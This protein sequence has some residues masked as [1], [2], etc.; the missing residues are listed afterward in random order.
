M[1]SH[2]DSVLTATGAM[3]STA[4]KPLP[5]SLSGWSDPSS[6]LSGEPIPAAMERDSGSLPSRFAHGTRVF[7]SA[8]NNPPT[9]APPIAN[10]LTMLC[11]QFNALEVV[12]AR[13]TGA[14]RLRGSMTATWSIPSLC[15]QWPHCPACLSTSTMND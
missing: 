7:F 5:L 3:V 2:N 8:H 4:W 9:T 15:A 13:R 10:L 1:V 11:K 14:R 12:R 6:Q